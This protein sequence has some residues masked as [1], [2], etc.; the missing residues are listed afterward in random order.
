ML[1]RGCALLARGIRPGPE[2]RRLPECEF[3]TAQDSRGYA[4]RFQCRDDGYAIAWP[5][6]CVAALNSQEDAILLNLS[7]LWLAVD[8]PCGV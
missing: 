1:D 7:D 5:I 4:F 3:E 6:A 2:Y 8:G